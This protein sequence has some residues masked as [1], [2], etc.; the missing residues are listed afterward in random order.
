MKRVILSGIILLAG[1][2]AFGMGMYVCPASSYSDNALVE[3]VRNRTSDS[4]VQVYASDYD[5]DGESEAFIITKKTKEVQSLWFSG[6]QEVKRIAT[7]TIWTLESTGICPV[8]AR[9]KLFVAEGSYGGSGSWSY[10]CYV[11]NGKPILVKRAGEGLKQISGRDFAIFP[12]AF[13]SMYD[14]Q[15]HY[16][17]GHTCKEYYL[18]WTG[19]KFVEYEGKE[20]SI[21]KLKQ[22]RGAGRYLRQVDRLGY[23]IG[24]IYLRQ[25]GIIN[26]NVSKRDA[27]TKDIDYDNFTL[28][29]KGRGVTLKIKDKKGS[30][31]LQRSGYG[32]IYRAKGFPKS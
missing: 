1:M 30:N 11:K 3:K 18:K 2:T 14:G 29:V 6:R 8:D 22:Y 26:V 25:N 32:G 28:Q 24:K 20:L 17:L 27:D 5:D 7:A 13:D 9:Q 16:Y 19:T 12:S 15:E 4:I 10:C 23:Q 31:I 21:G